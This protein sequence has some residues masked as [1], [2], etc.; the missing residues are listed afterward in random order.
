[1]ADKGY[2]GKIANQG[3]QVVQAPHQNSPK[4]GRKSVIRG[5][6]LRAGKGGK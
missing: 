1:M 5:T 3:A 2:I 4:K 6:D